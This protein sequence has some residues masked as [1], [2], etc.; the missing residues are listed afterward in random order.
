MASNETDEKTLLAD[1][2]KIL[3][4]LVKELQNVTK[5]ISDQNTAIESIKTSLHEDLDKIREQIWLGN[6]ITASELLRNPAYKDKYVRALGNKY[7]MNLD[8]EL[9]S[10]N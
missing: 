10:T 1:Q 8:T 7:D 6:K 9:P 4:D 3:E 5:A 2:N